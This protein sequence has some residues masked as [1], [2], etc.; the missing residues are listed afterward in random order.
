MFTRLALS[1]SRSGV[2][3]G[4]GSVIPSDVLTTVAGVPLTT[5]N[6]EY[7]SSGSTYSTPTDIIVS[8]LEVAEGAAN[9]TLID[10]CYATGANP[11]D[12]HSFEIL[13]ATY[14]KVAGNTLLVN[15]DS[16]GQSDETF[17]IRTTDPSGLTFDEEVTVTFTPVSNGS[18]LDDAVIISDGGWTVTPK[19]QGTND[20]FKISGKGGG[21]AKLI[22]DIGNPAPGGIYTMRVSADW[23]GFSRS[24]SLALVGWGVRTNDE[25]I[26]FVG[27]KGD[28]SLPT[29]IMRNTQLYGEQLFRKKSGLSIDDGGVA[30]NGTR[31]GPNWYQIEFNSA[32]TSYTFRTSADGNTWDDEYIAA[33]PNPLANISEAVDFG[34]A[35]YME[36]SDKGVLNLTI[37][38]WSAKPTEIT[39]V[40]SNFLEGS[41]GQN[42]LLPSA[43]AVGH[44]CVVGYFAT[45]NDISMSTSAPTGWTL[46]GSEKDTPNAVIMVAK[47]LNAADITA[48]SVDFGADATDFVDGCSVVFSTNWPINSFAKASGGVDARGGS[49]QSVTAGIAG[50]AHIT[51]GFTANPFESAPEFDV[52]NS[53]AFATE[54]T[55][56]VVD[57]RMGYTIYNSDDTPAAHSIGIDAGALVTTRIT[58]S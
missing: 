4:G 18:G 17:T 58:I 27:L 48:G 56:G 12:W 8:N 43:A 11:Q 34:P 28:G 57:C 36:N 54:L 31:D 42:I 40:D 50:T 41:S 6:G 32:G 9:G 47:V 14:V 38:V 39:F 15:A 29:T 21:V 30:Q 7:L 37:T 26:H 52:A 49:T 20:G 35:I 16:T 44:L 33:T 13:S 45:D 5:G 1:L 46:I 51:M 2:G 19:T 10:Y 24:G 53:P 23:T 3:G 55:S 25:D 22:L